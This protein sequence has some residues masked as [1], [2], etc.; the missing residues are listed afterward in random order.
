MIGGGLAGCEAAYQISKFGIKVNLFEMRPKIKT[1]AHQTNYLGELPLV[2]S[3][4]IHS[5]EGEPVCISEPESE[6]AK[7]YL[8]IA[9]NFKKFPNI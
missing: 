5:D 2:T 1:E 8:K 4:R 7:I 6:I 9:E 3:L